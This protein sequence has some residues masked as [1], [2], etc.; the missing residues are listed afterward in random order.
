[1]P[2]WF[3]K[4]SGAPGNSF[5]TVKGWGITLASSTQR[6][7]SLTSPPV[8][9]WKGTAKCTRRCHICPSRPSSRTRSVSMQ[10][11]K[12]YKTFFLGKLSWVFGKLSWSGFHGKFCKVV[13]FLRKARSLSLKSTRVG[14]KVLIC[15][16]VCTIKHYLFLIYGLHTFSLFVHSS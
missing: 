5:F 11:W 16:G 2:Q 15:P 9:G 7:P 6:S 13:H 12:F 3:P 4:F 1:M 8:F 10:R 14:W